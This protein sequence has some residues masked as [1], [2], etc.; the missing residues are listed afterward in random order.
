[1][2][3]WDGRISPVFDVARRL[4]VVDT[5]G[6]R[7]LAREE[8][9]LEERDCGARARRL[10]QL[11]PDVLI[12]GAISRPLESML[13][14]AGIQVIPQTCGTTDEVLRCFVSG[15]MDEQRFLM[16]GSCG[17]R[18]RFRGVRGRRRGRTN[19]RRSQAP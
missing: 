7:E 13:T 15:E 12:C 3:S 6:D 5:E 4:L 17:R 14:A 10:A 18:R 2:P 11:A 16:P 9:T 1:M 8:L 19:P